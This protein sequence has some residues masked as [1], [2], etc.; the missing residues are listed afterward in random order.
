MLWEGDALKIPRKDKHKHR[1]NKVN[2]PISSCS[3][4]RCHNKGSKH[5]KKSKSKWAGVFCP[6]GD[7]LTQ[8]GGLGGVPASESGNQRPVPPPAPCTSGGY[9]HQGRARAAS[10]ALCPRPQP[11]E[12]TGGGHPELGEHARTPTG[13]PTL[14][15]WGPKDTSTCPGSANPAASTPFSY[16]D[17]DGPP[18]G[19]ASASLLEVGHAVQRKVSYRRSCHSQTDV[20]KGS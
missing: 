8:G 11:L 9:A 1:L 6:P 5:N 17:T 14:P 10:R 19:S 16:K 15:H 18:E 4:G 20:R 13:A 7:S 12:G 2:R 3:Q